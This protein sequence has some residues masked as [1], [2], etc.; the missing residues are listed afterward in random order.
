M[1]YI[2][3]IRYLSITVILSLV[4]LLLT[5]YMV[6]KKVKGALLWGILATYALGIICQ[7]TGLYVVDVEKEMFN[8]IPSW[9]I[10]SLPPS[11]K[12]IF[13]QFD[14]GGAFKLGFE[15]FVIVFSFLFVDLFD[16]VGTL[17]GVANKADLLDDEGNLP[18]AKKL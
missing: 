12:P 6:H 8:L 1:I 9:K 2:S 5:I 4:G 18:K 17:I 15:F 7:L 13:F 14:F 16:T 11:L 10:V 3:F